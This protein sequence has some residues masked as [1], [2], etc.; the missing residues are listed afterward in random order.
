MYTLPSPQPP[1]THAKMLKGMSSTWTREDGHMHKGSKKSSK[2]DYPLNDVQVKER[3]WGSQSP[4]LA[5]DS[6]PPCHHGHLSLV[7]L[8]W[9]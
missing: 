9:A 1:P 4:T 5:N 7:F 2:G 6:L 3:F 8:G